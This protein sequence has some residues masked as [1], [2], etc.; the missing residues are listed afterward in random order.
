MILIVLSKRKQIRP[1]GSARD[2]FLPQLVSSERKWAGM[3]LTFVCVIGEDAV[4]DDD[5]P[6]QQV[7]AQ[8]DVTL[9]AHIC[10]GAHEGRDAEDWHSDRLI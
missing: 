1:R 2:T 5:E 9:I 7:M 8:L 4:V 6:L 10:N 3:A